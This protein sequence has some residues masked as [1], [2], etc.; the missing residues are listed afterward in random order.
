MLFSGNSCNICE[1]TTRRNLEV[2]IP[3][4]TYIS[5]MDFS[6]DEVKRLFELTPHILLGLSNVGLIENVF[7]YGPKESMIKRYPNAENY[8]IIVQPSQMGVELYMWAYGHGLEPL[9]TFFDTSMIFTPIEG[10]ELGTAFPTKL[11]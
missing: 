8:G 1:H 11:K 9:T 3:L 7:L 2:Y 6:E 4:E 10:L 5:A